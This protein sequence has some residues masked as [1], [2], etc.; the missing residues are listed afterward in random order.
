MALQRRH[1][2]GSARKSAAAIVIA[3]GKACRIA[4]TLANGIC[5][6]A[7]RKVIVIKISAPTRTNMRRLSCFERLRIATLVIHTMIKIGGTVIILRR[8]TA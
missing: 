8:N 4:V 7:V 1:P 6:R 3:S 5:L 2:T